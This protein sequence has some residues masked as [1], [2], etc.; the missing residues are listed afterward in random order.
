MSTDIAHECFLNLHGETEARLRRIQSIHDDSSSQRLSV[1]RFVDVLLFT[2]LSPK[3][4]ARDNVV[5]TLVFDAYIL[6]IVQGIRQGDTR[7][8]VGV[9]PA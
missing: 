1:F 3:I 2:A 4:S 5:N 6:R 9:L 7:R 8:L